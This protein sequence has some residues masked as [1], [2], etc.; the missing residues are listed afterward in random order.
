MHLGE[1]DEVWASPQ[2]NPWHV[3]TL[4][5]FVPDS[6]LSNWRRVV[7]AVGTVAAGKFAC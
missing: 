2:R 5:R 7:E 1:R 3:W 6:P 4:V